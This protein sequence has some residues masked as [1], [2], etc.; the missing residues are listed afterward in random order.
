MVILLATASFKIVLVSTQFALIS[1]ELL[2]VLSVIVL[3]WQHR[4][5]QGPSLPKASGFRC[6]LYPLP[7]LFF[8]VVSIMALIYT[9]ITNSFEALL[10]GCLIIGGLLVYPLLQGNGNY[11]SD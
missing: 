5:I 9:M 4:I 6:P 7:Q 2:G 1:C 11:E 10:G 3:R 8:A